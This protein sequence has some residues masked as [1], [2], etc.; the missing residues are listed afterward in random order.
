MPPRQM[1]TLRRANIFLALSAGSVYHNQFSLEGANMLDHL[2]PVLRTVAIVAGGVLTVVATVAQTRDKG[3]C[4]TRWG[5]SAIVMGLF[6]L[7]VALA[8]QAAEQSKAQADAANVARTTAEQIR[9]ANDVLN[10][11]QRQSNDTNLILSNLK[12]QGVRTKEMLTQMH[13]HADQLDIAVGQTI[14]LLSKFSY[15][16]ADACIL[17][18]ST[19]PALRDYISELE[20]RSA[21]FLTAARRTDADVKEGETFWRDLGEVDGLQV[22]WPGAQRFEW[23]EDG[24]RLP[25]PPQ[26]RISPASTAFPN[27]RKH[28]V[29]RTYLQ[30]LAASLTYR[31]CREPV[32]SSK[33]RRDVFSQFEGEDLCLEMHAEV[34]ALVYDPYYKRLFIELKGTRLNKGDEGWMDSGRII[35]YADLR[36]SQI[37]VTLFE[38]GSV[39]G[40]VVDRLLTTSLVTATS[41][42]FDGQPLSI[43]DKDFTDTNGRNDRV[44]TR[45]HQQG[46]WMYVVS[47][48]L[49]EAMQGPEEQPG[50]RL[51]RCTI[52]GE[53]RAQTCRLPLSG[54]RTPAS[55][56]FGRT[57]ATTMPASQPSTKPSATEPSVA[58]KPSGRAVGGV[59]TPSAKP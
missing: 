9:Q 56:I 10:T 43:T 27:D 15:V 31:F 52:Q 47:D 24:R 36:G 21:T 45:Y 29:M 34:R 14:R 35:S 4:L 8:T 32:D 2:L 11:L 49:H 22:E 48:V 39:S 25:I 5:W 58:T 23:K 40:D 17:V 54:L 28:A 53:V 13:G 3:G 57:A 7:V 41:L 18:P 12:E 26:L 1:A 37:V 33:L 30:A 50:A 55:K 16:S 38:R 51:E 59:G 46:L 42:E 19:D 20:K 6:A 44:L